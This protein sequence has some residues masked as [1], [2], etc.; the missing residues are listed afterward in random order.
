MSASSNA[1]V[2]NTGNFNLALNLIPRQVRLQRK[3]PDVAETPQVR[4]VSPPPPPPVQNNPEPAQTQEVVPVN[5]GEAELQP[6]LSLLL[7]SVPQSY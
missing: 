4:I 1:K 7:A 2:F 5:L 3:C 6:W